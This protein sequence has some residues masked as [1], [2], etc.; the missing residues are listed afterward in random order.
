MH[1]SFMGAVLQ[2]S[3]FVRLPSVLF[4]ILPP[5]LFV[6]LPSIL[7]FSRGAEGFFLA[8]RDAVQDAQFWPY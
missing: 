1:M 2:V 7:R 6:G 3:I 8:T 5:V 4:V